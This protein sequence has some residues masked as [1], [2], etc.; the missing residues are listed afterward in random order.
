VTSQ[1]PSLPAEDAAPARG[2]GNI[3]REQQIDAWVDHHSDAS[4][5]FLGFGETSTVD[6]VREALDGK[7]SELG[8][9]TA[10][11]QRYLLDRVL[12]RWS[13]G[14]GAG[15]GGA[16]DLVQSLGNNRQ[17]Q[18][19]VAER[20][21]AKAASLMQRPAGNGSINDPH[22][23]A[24]AYAL[25]AIQA[26]SG[27]LERT[28]S[29]YAPLRQLMNSLGPEAA[30]RLVQ[31]LNPATTGAGYYGMSQLQQRMLA[32]MNS[33]PQTSAT[34]A[35]VQTIFSETTPGSLHMLPAMQTHM[36]KALA[37]EWHPDNP[38]MQAS[39]ATR[40][41]GIFATDQGQQL[42]FGSGNEGRIPLDARVNALAIIR[43]DTSI[44][45]ATLR[46]TQDPWTNQ[47]ILGPMARANAQQYMSLRGDS[48]QTLNGTDLDNVVGYAMGLP[49]TLPRDRSAASA[50]A[51]AANGRFSYFAQG[52]GQRPV[53]AVVDQ[54]RR[55][56][57][58]T[59]HVTVLPIEFGSSAY[60]PVQLPL[61]RVQTPGGDRYVDNTGRSYTSFDDW[62]E[63]NQLPAGS[64]I[65]PEQGHLSATSDGQARLASSNTPN[66]PDTTWKQVKGVLNDVALV[67][68][69]IAG[70]AVILGT[71]GAATPIIA[72]IAVAS[73]AWG[74]YSTGSELLDRYQHGQS[75]D[76]IHDGT[77]RGLW[78][79]LAANTAG[80]GAFASEAALARIASTEGRLTSTAAWTIGTAKTA[81]TVTN[82]AALIN[83]GIDLSA[84]WGAMSPEQRA[85]SIL[86]MGF[87][88]VTMLAG[89]RQARSPGDLFNPAS[90]TQALADAYQPSVTRTTTL[91]GSRVEIVTE[92]QTGRPVILAGEQAS[93]ADVQLH[94]NVAR[95]MARN[96]GLQGQINALLGRAEPAPG[97]LAYSAKYEA[98]KLNQKVSDL[99]A[100]LANPHLTPQQRA[101][102]QGDIDTTNAYLEQQL[103][104]L[105]TIARSPGSASVAAPSDGRARAEQLPGLAEAL[106]TG[107]YAHQGY[108]FRIHQDPE[109]PPEIVRMEGYDRTHPRLA[110]YELDNRTWGV[111][112]VDAQNLP[113]YA[114]Q[115]TGGAASSAR[116]SEALSP[117][118]SVELQIALARRQAASARYSAATD[119]A[120]RNAAGQNVVVQSHLI[121]ELGARGYMQAEF[122]NARMIYAGTRQFE[123]DQVY[124]QVMPNGSLRFIV[125]EAKGGNS[126]LGTRLVNTTVE[127]QGTPEYFEATAESMRVRGGDAGRVGS[128]LLRAFR[129]GKTSDG[130]PAEVAYL[131]VRTPISSQ[132]ATANVGTVTAKQFELTGQHP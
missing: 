41:A 111:R 88:G 76:P 90:M 29:D 53:Q 49:P 100:R 82:G 4:G 61:F 110:P 89:A 101:Q 42:L 75:I 59:P 92:P 7:T 73:G 39:E 3:G 6:H 118:Q 109:L 94:V 78:L 48:P 57:G 31:A 30:A 71:G 91:G 38:S 108:Y 26:T 46:Q 54:I 123:F 122:P 19:L 18:G 15:P 32:A 40:L 43:A 132:G 130:R 24:R 68:G 87:W 120:T 129:V 104:S 14:R 33:G 97:T 81:A 72:G 124:R 13:E 128:D 47:A 56:G 17:L 60:G 22:A 44:N 20:L 96:Q 106:E 58:A 113:A 23:Q 63:H 25:D 1:S 114:P 83:A 69:I 99:Q 93:P 45:A 2:Q 66:T 34:S 67:G 115:I 105:A 74:A 103:T 16:A 55:L 121:G 116:L 84:N 64:M 9:L 62:K 85:Q 5:G 28:P 102:L 95:T 125:V 65:Y 70:G 50:Q 127:T 86:S 119:S 11:E 52:P 112:P 80:M 131:V 107:P 126:P 36:A 12:D 79:G 21:A 98:I 77:A 10:D 35:V 51:D 27:P 117:G 8:R 37:R